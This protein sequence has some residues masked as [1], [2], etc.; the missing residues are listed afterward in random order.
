[1]LSL[2]KSVQGIVG[3]L[4][5]TDNDLSYTNIEDWRKVQTYLFDSLVSL[6][7][8]EG[9][10]YEEDAERILA[11]LMGYRIA[12]RNPLIVD[13]ALKRAEQ[14]LPHV[15]DPVLK[16]YL[17]VFCYTECEDDELEEESYRQLESLKLS[18]KE[19]EVVVIEKVL[20]MVANGL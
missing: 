8:K 5:M 20:L 10:T 13:R 14:I 11:I 6:D 19:E 12:V 7:Q 17:T 3:R 4:L 1:M 9:D 15:Q 16:C 2:A 18:G